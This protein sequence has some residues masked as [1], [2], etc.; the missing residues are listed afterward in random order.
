MALEE[1]ST[2][3]N[4]EDL[5]SKI[6]LNSSNLST[7]PL[8]SKTQYHKHFPYTKKQLQNI[9][10]PTL[11][12]L[13]AGGFSSYGSKDI[14]EVFN[15]GEYLGKLRSINTLKND[16]L[17]K[18]DL[19]KILT[20]SEKTE[21]TRIDEGFKETIKYLDEKSYNQK[22]WAQTY[23]KAKIVDTFSTNRGE[24]QKRIEQISYESKKY[25][26]K[27]I[28]HYDNITPKLMKT[29]GERE[30][31]PFMNL[32]I[33]QLYVNLLYQLLNDKW[34]NKDPIRQSWKTTN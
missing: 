19:L 3:L 4:S 20:N 7:T 10:I 2:K 22:N 11:T 33:K 31:I 17:F 27:S 9:D 26:L 34:E 18:T 25:F 12:S 23:K 15:K 30:H 21:K 6:E 29:P 28:I 32:G 14:L 5:E 16:E 1:D 24:Q 13:I 8:V